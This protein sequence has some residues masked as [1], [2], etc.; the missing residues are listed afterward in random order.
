MKKELAISFFWKALQTFGK[1]GFFFLVFILA[2]YLLSQQ[3]FG[4]Y[5]YVMASIVIF[6]LLCD[7][8]IS[9][10]TARHI[11]MR[12]ENSEVSS[13]VI[14]FS[15]SAVVFLLSLIFIIII[16]FF[17]HLFFKE[18]FNYVLY[19]LPLI[20]LIPLNSIQEGLYI[21]FE[22]FKK[23]SL[24]VIISGTLNILLS[25][26][27]I[28]NYGLVGAIGAQI[29]FYFVS[30]I[31]LIFLHG[32]WSFYFKTNIVKDILKYSVWIGISGLGY[33][34]FSRIDIIVLGYYG[35]IKEIANYEII[36][37][38]FSLM[39]IPTYIFS[40]VIFPKI[41]LLFNQ[42]NREKIWNLYKKTLIF[43]IFMSGS[44]ILFFLILFEYIIKILF[45]GYDV[46]ELKWIFL[47]LLPL[48]FT[49]MITAT[50]SSG[51]SVPTG[52][53]KLNMR[54][55]LISGLI[56]VP[57]VIYSAIHYGFRG[58]IISTVLVKLV[59]DILYIYIY[60]T[61]VKWKK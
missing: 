43:T 53:A 13:E 2:S 21:G 29:L 10:A 42:D 20:F 28:K 6:T 59:S 38:I 48:F 27:L 60:T 47:L 34:L 44:I 25:Y 57:L 7:F 16:F 26:V 22:K 19:A 11:A 5:N 52:H 40:S 49:Q 17:G 61:I 41:S 14:I 3:E 12:R 9:Q 36:N 56:L 32:K 18:N 35:Y 50:I 24:I 58:V 33:I 46:F 51:F 4:I 15:M 31:L 8:G 55:L 39:I 30:L 1:Q 37:K 54:F 45:S 23:L